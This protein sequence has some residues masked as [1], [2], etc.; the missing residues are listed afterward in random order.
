MATGKP[1]VALAA[2]LKDACVLM[3]EGWRI[4]KQR[5]LQAFITLHL[6]AQIPYR[7][8]WVSIAATRVQQLLKLTTEVALLNCRFGFAEQ[9]TSA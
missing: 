6:C 2:R 1:C 9:A 3:R 7:F 8:H 4:G 5:R